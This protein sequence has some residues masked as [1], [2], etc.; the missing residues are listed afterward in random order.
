ML[1]ISR[2][3][4]GININFLVEEIFKNFIE[5]DEKIIDEFIKATNCTRK[6]SANNGIENSLF[7]PSTW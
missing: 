1:F 2:I 6:D 7:M 5:L 3:I 4:K